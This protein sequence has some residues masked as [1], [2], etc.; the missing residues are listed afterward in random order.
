MTGACSPHP[1]Y[2]YALPMVMAALL[3]GCH[4]TPGSTALATENA[5]GDGVALARACADRDGWSDP[6]PPARIHGNT[7]YV[8][9]CGITVLLVT[10][11]DGHMLID[12]ATAEAVPHILANVRAL[13]FDPR[14]IR[15]LL[16]SHEHID[17]AG[18][19]AAL[20]AA[21]GAQLWVREPAQK[22]LETGQVDPADPQAGIIADMTPVR[23]DRI[24]GDGQIIGVGTI[25]LTAIA[26]PG[27]TV[28]GTS[29]TWTS[30]AGADCRTIA[31]ADSLS[32]V[33]ADDYRFTDH[34]GRVAP[35]RVTFDRVAALPCDILVTPHPGASALFERLA[36]ETA[37]IDDRLCDHY[38]DRAR[39]RLDQRL[40]QEGT[41]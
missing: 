4:V 19:F 3:A 2:L 9:T 1:T 20:K 32:A 26:T 12:A 8:G 30:C 33:S 18:G 38:A 28:G 27:H 35:F 6:A 5:H 29:W 37:L 13:G 10:S 14:D 31:Y 21:T 15:Y 7:Y 24:V 17:H 34:P 41:R 39:S 40:M 23:V 22:I 25:A 36:G 11:P 16:N